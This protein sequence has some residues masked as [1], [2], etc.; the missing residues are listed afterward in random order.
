MTT[1]GD[2]EDGKL[3]V[4]RKLIQWLSLSPKEVSTEKT[5][6]YFSLFR[7]LED[8]QS[9]ILL[10]LGVIFAIAAGAPLP[11]IGVIFARIIDVF[12]PS[13]E[14]VRSRISQLLAVGLFNHSLLK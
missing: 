4:W 12:P 13:E 1:S 6:S 2:S 11:I 14:E 9:R 3:S 10:F 5:Y 7:P 8:L